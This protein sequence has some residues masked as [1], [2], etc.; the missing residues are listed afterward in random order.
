MGAH[1]SSQKIGVGR[2]HGRGT[3]MVVALR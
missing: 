3:C 2:L 1:S